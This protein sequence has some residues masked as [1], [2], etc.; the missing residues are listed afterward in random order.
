MDLSISEL[1]Y[2]AGI[3]KR[4]TRVFY[5]CVIILAHLY[6]HFWLKDIFPETSFFRRLCY[7]TNMSFF[8]NL[9]YYSYV[10]IMHVPYGNRFKHFKFLQAYFKFC[11]AISFVVF[12]LYWGMVI[13]DPSLLIS[14]PDKKM[15]PLALDL[16]LHGA[17]FILNF[18][19][20]VFVFPKSDSKAIGVLSYLLFSFCY[21]F[22]MKFLYHSHGIEVYPFVSK[23]G[24]LE[25]S[26]L[27]GIATFLVFLGD[28][29]YRFFLKKEKSSDKNFIRGLDS[30][31]KTKENLEKIENYLK[32]SS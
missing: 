9:I 7:L 26:L 18:V 5:Y 19:E 24:I 32:K 12:I 14:R 31:E 6:M 17:N 3:S 29:T 23:L 16:F 13:S 21:A 2:S 15:L 27:I 1:S 30:I 25:F 22:F 8:L 20:H 11:Y 4:N 10:L 28:L